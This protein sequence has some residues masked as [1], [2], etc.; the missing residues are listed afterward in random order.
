MIKPILRK[1]EINIVVLL[2]KGKSTREVVK[3][4]GFL[5]STMNRMR[6]KYYSS[7]ELPQ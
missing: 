6:R 2:I 5:Q 1:K 7:L 4:L 3:S